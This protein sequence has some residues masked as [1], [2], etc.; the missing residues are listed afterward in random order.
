MIGIDTNV[1]VLYLT[2]DDSVQSKKA[3]AIMEQAQD[4]GRHPYSS[5]RV[6]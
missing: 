4:G 5:H 6:M 2:Q 3:G 1:L